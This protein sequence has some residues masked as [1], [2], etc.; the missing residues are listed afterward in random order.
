VQV[1][2]KFLPICLQSS[3][4]GYCSLLQTAV[5]VVKRGFSIAGLAGNEKILM[6]GG[7]GPTDDVL[8]INSTAG[9]RGVLADYMKNSHLDPF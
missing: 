5:N 8:Q 3:R 6:P 2:G 9:A 4:Q 1:N 7:C